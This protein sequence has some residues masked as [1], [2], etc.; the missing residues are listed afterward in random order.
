MNS[1]NLLLNNNNNSNLD[2]NKIS[3]LN[4]LLNN[5]QTVRTLNYGA[6]NPTSLRSSLNSPQLNVV[7]SMDNNMLD[8]DNQQQQ[9]Q[10]Q[11]QSSN[12]N[13]NNFFPKEIEDEVD[14]CIQSLFK[15]TSSG[16]GPNSAPN[17]SVDERK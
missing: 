13:N 15:P 3:V 6:A 17:L 1:Q 10:Q 2:P 9:Q 5:P 11:Q 4:N 16:G 12:N 8:K 7:A 14:K